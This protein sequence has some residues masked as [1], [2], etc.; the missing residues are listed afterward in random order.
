MKAKL[1]VNEVCKTL[2][3]SFLNKQCELAISN[4]KKAAFLLQNDQYVFQN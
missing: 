4:R 2:A 1:E 3:T